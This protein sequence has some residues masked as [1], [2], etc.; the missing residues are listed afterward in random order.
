MKIEFEDQPAI[1]TY[2]E[3]ASDMAIVGLACKGFL[4][5]L[6]P[7]YADDWPLAGRDTFEARLARLRSTRIFAALR[8]G[9]RIEAN[10]VNPYCDYANER[11]REESQ[12]NPG[13]R[14]DLHRGLAALECLAHDLERA[15]EGH[16]FQ[17][18]GHVE[19]WLMRCNPYV[20]Y[21]HVSFRDDRPDLMRVGFLLFQRMGVDAPAIRLGQ[22]AKG[23]WE[24]FHTHKGSLS[25]K[26]DFLF[27][28]S[29][30]R[31]EFRKDFPKSGGYNVFF[32]YNRED[33]GKVTHIG[34]ELYRRGLVHWQDTRS[35]APGQQWEGAVQTAIV[36][37]PAALVF[38]GPHG[39]GYWQVREIDLLLDRAKEDRGSRI[40]PVVLP[41]GTIPGDLTGEIARFNMV[42]VGDMEDRS[43]IDEIAQA[44]RKANGFG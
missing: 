39:L 12:F 31:V 19:V 16:E 22:N 42:N 14:E 4:S 32:S 29:G 30:N 26:R 28:W 43:Y 10:F 37:C 27:K 2:Y 17:I 38:F 23:I 25:G 36:K 11:A 24:A 7:T 1:E 33:F 41:G 44:V 40:I 9:L 18:G 8:D 34:E 35:L 6:C 5:T 20:A 21:T 15:H 13:C 3:E